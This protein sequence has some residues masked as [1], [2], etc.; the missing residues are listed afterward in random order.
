MIKEDKD[1]LIK[2]VHDYDEIHDQMDVMQ[3]TINDLVE[4]RNALVERVDELKLKEK[5]FFE[6]L[7]EKYGAAALTPNKLMEIARC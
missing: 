7:L 3:M 6:E 2:F 1:R 5:A 4:K